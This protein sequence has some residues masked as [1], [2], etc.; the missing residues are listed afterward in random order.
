MKKGELQ[1][2][3]RHLTPTFCQDLCGESE[4]IEERGED[5]TD[6]VQHWDYSCK[7]KDF[8][9]MK[10]K[11]SALGKIHQLFIAIGSRLHAAR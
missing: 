8:G 11:S 5:I 2:G 3:A 10:N 7:I 9:V 4:H 6:D 1:I